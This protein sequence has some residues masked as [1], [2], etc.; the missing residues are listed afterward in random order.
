MAHADAKDVVGDAGIEGR[1]GRRI[2]HRRRARAFLEHAG[3]VPLASV[4]RAVASDFLVKIA[5]AGLSN[6]TVNNCAATLSSAF[7]SARRRGRFTGDNPFEDQKRRA[8][9]ESYAS[10][11]TAELQTLFDSTKHGQLS[12]S[13][14]TALPWFS[15]IVDRS[16]GRS[17]CRSWPSGHQAFSDARNPARSAAWP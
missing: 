1:R 2:G 6:R 8:G 4:T 5:A 14:E 11:E 9:G 7:K 10:F 16:S 3:D 15:L 17:P 13:P 12:I